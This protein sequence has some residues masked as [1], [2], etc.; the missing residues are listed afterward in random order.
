MSRG[1]GSAG[2]LQNKQEVA[3]IT[4][5]CFWSHL[6]RFSAWRSWLIIRAEPWGLVIWLPL[7]WSAGC[8][9]ICGGLFPRIRCPRTV[10]S[11]FTQRFDP[12]FFSN[13]VQVHGLFLCSSSWTT[14]SP[15][16]CFLQQQWKRM[17]TN[18][19][20]ENIFHLLHQTFWHLR[21][22]HPKLPET[23]SS[24]RDWP[25][26]PR[27]ERCLWLPLTCISHLVPL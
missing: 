21:Q 8:N 13:I 20:S 25:G 3:L 10:C 4:C 27:C 6:G 5:Q 15:C 2:D 22:L 1:G 11:D 16:S 19:P 26:V 24:C 17:E 23:D 14:T 12:C 18:Q 7:V 9:C